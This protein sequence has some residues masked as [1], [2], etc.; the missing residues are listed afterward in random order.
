MKDWGTSI[1]RKIYQTRKKNK[2]HSKIN[3]YSESKIKSKFK[4]VEKNRINDQ[5]MQISF[6]LL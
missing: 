4:V 2:H 1:T 5:N 6:F 3:A